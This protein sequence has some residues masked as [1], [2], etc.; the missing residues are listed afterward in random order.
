[1][2][3]E[4]SNSLK[5][6]LFVFFAFLSLLFIF[7][8]PI[9]TYAISGS[10]V[11]PSPVPSSSGGGHGAGKGL[12]NTAAIYRIMAF[13]VE[14][15]ED[16]ASKGYFGI[17]G[18]K[19]IFKR[20]GNV[21]YADDYLETATSA[22]AG[23]TKWYYWSSTWQASTA[24]HTSVHIQSGA[25]SYKLTIDGYNSDDAKNLAKA[26]NS[27]LSNLKDVS[28][29]CKALEN[30]D[31]YAS[32]DDKL[33][34]ELPGVSRGDSYVI[35]IEELK[36]AVED[37]KYYAFTY[38]NWMKANSA[39]RA[40][41]NPGDYN[42]GYL[43]DPTNWLRQGNTPPFKKEGYRFDNAELDRKAAYSLY[44][45][46][47]GT[48]TDSAAGNIHIQY[49]GEPNTVDGEF[50]VAGTV[51]KKGTNDDDGEYV[52]SGNENSNYWFNPEDSTWY[53]SNEWK[54]LSRVADKGIIYGT[55]S[56]YVNI[57]A[58]YYSLNINKKCNV[59]TLVN[60]FNNLT[61][62]SINWGNKLLTSSYTG[63]DTNVGVEIKPKKLN[64]KTNTSAVMDKVV[65][66]STAFSSYSN[67]VSNS[68]ESTLNLSIIKLIKDTTNKARLVS[69]SDV[70]NGVNLLKDK[71][72]GVAVEFSAKSDK[73]TSHKVTINID[74]T[75]H[76]ISAPE[77]WND[78]YPIAH[79]TSCTLDKKAVAFTVIPNSARNDSAMSSAVEGSRTAGDALAGLTGFGSSMANG[80]GCGGDIIGLGAA[81]TT[82]V[83]GYTV[84]EVIIAEP[85]ST[86][87]K[88]TL[89]LDSYMLNRYYDNVIQTSSTL[90]GNRIWWQLNKNFTI[91][92][93]NYNIG[94]NCP[95]GCWVYPTGY[96]GKQ[97]DWNIE[98]H[99]A[100]SGTTHVDWDNSMRQSYFPNMETGVWS[101]SNRIELASWVSE[102]TEFW[103]KPSGYIV[104]YGFNLVRAASGDK[105]SISG[106][107]YPNYADRDPSNLLKIQDQ[108]GVVPSTVYNGGAQTRKPDKTDGSK[109][110]TTTESL[111]MKSR[112]TLYHGSGYSLQN[113]NHHHA[114]EGHWGSTTVSVGNPPTSVSVPVWVVDKPEVNINYYT[115]P[116]KMQSG[117]LKNNTWSSNTLDYS[118]TNLYYKYKSET[119]PNGLNNVLGST[120]TAHKAISN[121]AKTSIDSGHVGGTNEYRF[122]NVRYNGVTLSF[123][124]EVKMVY[125]IGGTTWSQIAESDGSI[126]YNDIYTMG[127]Y[128]RKTQSSSLYLFKLNGNGDGSITGTTY[129]DAM[130][131]G[132]NT[133]GNTKV[134]IPAGSDVNVAADMN[135][136]DIDLYAYAL[137]IIDK[138][139]DSPSFKNS[140]TTTKNYQSIVKSD[141]N[142]YQKWMG[143][144]NVEILK[145]HFLDWTNTILD[146]ENFGADF[147]LKVNGSTKSENF[148]ATIGY[149]NRNTTITEDGV[150]QLVVENGVLQTSQGDYN[151]M[152]T[153]IAADYECTEAEA[154]EIWNASGMHT[155]IL[156]AIESSTSDFNNSG[157]CSYN[158]SW[159][160]VLGN[161]TNWYDEKTYTFVV[162]RF[163]NLDNKFCDIIASDKID[164]NLAP[165]GVL[166]DKQ[167]ANAGNT[168]NANWTVTI[169]FD[170]AKSSD[171]NDYLLDSGTYYTPNTGTSTSGSSNFVT[172]NSS[173][174][175]LINKA[176]VKNADFLI[177]ASSTSDFGY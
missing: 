65:D 1:M 139:V 28:A 10:T 150:Y 55:D 156:N 33:A 97:K 124:P 70:T 168:A 98:W 75:G 67:R 146:V 125:K 11:V 89:D 93:E 57:Y 49:Q 160:S 66:G 116:S 76:V 2:R 5:K 163:T 12:C 147:E 173:H 126:T 115:F 13:K 172:A 25:K 91:I 73:V 122:A 121:A 176:P 79:H 100:S 159:T 175:I 177:P 40:N 80:T 50:K 109:L 169:Y 94:T 56:G 134:M 71:K 132:S 162:R 130:Q 46:I 152:I 43:N 129:S 102:D 32:D 7:S 9:T 68:S 142:V 78:T 4:K 140:A 19:V 37:G 36:L 59:K 128:L 167:N 99:D 17:N 38:G 83:D 53:P 72:L 61:G 174:T 161:S 138:S 149:I 8:R 137:D 30:Y 118:W 158:P 154:T 107:H 90:A 64:G 39:V 101:H 23:S 54:V 51:I 16:A 111:H 24:A 108:F 104:D 35:V 18:K 144:S 164:Y 165:N 14:S 112:F 3:L 31:N 47:R 85:E 6:F 170:N 92:K 77:T 41:Y 74:E 96:T 113:N 27:S 114:E 60:K 133:L 58:D 86:P 63:Y 117:Y 166:N 21:Y 151:K 127:E 136:I 20:R 148:G 143:A 155:A 131:G 52:E 120:L 157:V 15:P 153:Q 105:R 45:D 29:F 145:N 22:T 88:G 123:Y 103:T 95:R 141:E 82:P 44:G 26:A 84:Y 48:S 34:D 69:S 106:I 81:T 87:D 42:T 62:F 135:G 110:A 171:V 119:I